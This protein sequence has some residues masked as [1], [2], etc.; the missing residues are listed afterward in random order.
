MNLPGHLAV[1]Y[2]ASGHHRRAAEAWPEAR[3][4]R[5][6]PMILGTI[7]PDL[8]DKSLMVLDVYPWGRTVGHSILVWTLLALTVALRRRVLGGADTDTTDRTKATG[9]TGTGDDAEA[10][11]WFVAGGLSHIATD[12]TNDVVAGL[13]CTGYL[14]STWFTWPY[15]NPDLYPWKIAWEGPTL[16]GCYTGYELGVLLLAAIVMAWRN[17]G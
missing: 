4:R 8:V 6:Y 11:S 1:A 13:T 17:R 2:L 15:L 3:R 5:L 9:S 16:R 14:F 10:A 7:L 12:M